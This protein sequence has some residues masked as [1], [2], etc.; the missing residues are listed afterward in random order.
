MGAAGIHQLFA[1]HHHVF[2]ETVSLFNTVEIAHGTLSH[3]QS[4]ASKIVGLDPFAFEFFPAI[5]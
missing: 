4:H 3:K 2:T 5:G 1:F